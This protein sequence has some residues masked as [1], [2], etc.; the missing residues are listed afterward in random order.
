MLTARNL[1]KSYAGRVVV[2]ALSLQVEPGRIV[3]LLGPNGAGK[4]TTLGMLYGFVQ[5]D[6]GSI[7]IDGH[8]VMTD[9]RTARRCVGIVPQEDNLD[10]DFSARENLIHFAR[11]YRLCGGVARARVTELLQQIGLTDHSGKSMEELS[12]GMK[13]RLVLGRALLHQPKILF[14][15]EPTTGLDPE[16]RQEFWKLV[17][18]LREQGCGVLLTTH[19]MEEAERLCDEVM[20]L[21]KGYVIRTGTPKSL[22]T[23][24][25]G[26]A[27]IEVEG[28]PSE[29]LEK[30]ARKYQTWFRSYSV[31]YLIG[32]RA[33]YLNEL[34][35]KIE[36]LEPK[37]FH[38]RAGNLEDVFLCLTGEALS[39]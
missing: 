38:R 17:L 12:G 22:I 9:G 27:V 13:R 20:L 4:T 19:Y 23:E 3:G 5:P 8:D 10:P 16:A 26:E 35:E 1:T 6:H 31:G 30:L 25:V 14:L 7:E 11:Y 34:T 24:I 32:L 15:D 39:Q 2:N 33:P 29:T 21:Q 28:V 18:T 36:R 37:R